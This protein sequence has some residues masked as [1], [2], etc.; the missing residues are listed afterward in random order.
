VDN[1]D[2]PNIP[3]VEAHGTYREVGLQIGTQCK[4]QITGMRSQMK[5]IIPNGVTW[6]A[7][8]EQSRLYITYSR[9]AYP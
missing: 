8:L 3:I 6:E 7:M 5:A 1:F 4:S 2:M 9:V